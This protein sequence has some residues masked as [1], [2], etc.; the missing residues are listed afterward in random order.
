MNVRA[1]NKR[2]FKNLLYGFW[3]ILFLFIFL[4]RHTALHRPAL[5]QPLIKFLFKRHHVV[6]IRHWAPAKRQLNV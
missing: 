5:Y 3:F 2:K 6:T 1:L 4:T